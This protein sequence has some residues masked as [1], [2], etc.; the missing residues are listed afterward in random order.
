[1][2]G[3]KK[4]ERQ[5]FFWETK[6]GKILKNVFKKNKWNTNIHKKEI[7][8]IHQE[9]KKKKISFMTNHSDQSVPST[10]TTSA[11]KIN[12]SLLFITVNEESSQWLLNLIPPN[13]FQESFLK[14][15]PQD[16]EAKIKPKPSTQVY[17]SSPYTK[18][19]TSKNTRT[20]KIKEKQ[21][22][23]SNIH[24]RPR[25]RDE[26]TFKQWWATDQLTFSCLNFKTLFFLFYFTLK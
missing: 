4:Q 1:M 11:L 20:K 23:P 22:Q 15:H 16:T 9:N 5:K 24:Y 2:C 13:F 7:K 8:T 6:K 3:R 18:C 26:N 17:H 21:L 25:R 19:R 12:P 10:M 14:N